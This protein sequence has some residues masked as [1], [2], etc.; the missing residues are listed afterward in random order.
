M[1]RL[2]SSFFGQPVSVIDAYSMIFGGKRF[3]PEKVHQLMRED[4]AHLLAWHQSQLCLEEC[5]EELEADHC[6]QL[7][8]RIKLMMASEQEVCVPVSVRR[9]MGERSTA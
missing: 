2:S 5:L 9:G 1:Q 8:H 7:L 6:G 3:T 4:E